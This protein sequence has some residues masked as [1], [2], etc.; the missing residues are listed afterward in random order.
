MRKLWPWII[1]AGIVLLAGLRSR[2][3]D[4]FPGRGGGSG[5]SITGAYNFA[6][7]QFNQIQT[8]NISIKDGTIITNPAIQGILGASTAVNANTL[9]STNSLDFVGAPNGGTL[10]NAHFNN[11]LGS[12]ALSS[13]A[14][15]SNNTIAAYESGIAG[16]GNRI[17]DSGF[18][19]RVV[20]IFAEFSTIS[21]GSAHSIIVG[22]L[23][24]Y[25]FQSRYSII[26]GWS[27]QVM[28]YSN[29]GVLSGWKNYC[30]APNSTIPGGYLNLI[31]VNTG[32]ALDT[33]LSQNSSAIGGGYSNRITG[34]AY[35]VIGGGYK[36]AITNLNGATEGNGLFCGYQ[37]IIGGN[38]P[39]YSVMCGGSFNL[40]KSGGNNFLG[41]GS[42]NNITDSSL[43]AITS[44]YQNSISNANYCFIGA[45]NTNV[46]R[47]SDYSFIV[48]G[49]GN[50]IT[51]RNNA[52][53]IGQAL[54]VTS[55]NV[56]EVGVNNV[57]K[58]R[59]HASGA[60]FLG[61]ISG[62]TNINLAEI[63]SAPT[64]AT[65]TAS[66]YVKD[67]AGIAK[68][69]M[70]WDDGTETLLGAGG[71]GTPGG[72]DTQLQVNNSGSFGG[73]AGITSP[74]NANNLK[75]A[76]WSLTIGA[77]TNGNGL[78][79]T[80][81][82]RFYG[83]SGPGSIIL[84]AATSGSFEITPSIAIIQTNSIVPNIVAPVADQALVIHSVAAA[85]GTNVITLTNRA[86]SGTPGGSDTHVQ[87]KSGSSFD[88][89]SGVV[90]PT[91]SGET[92]LNVTGLISTFN[93]LATNQIQVTGAGANG[94]NNLTVTNDATSSGGLRIL[95]PNASGSNA[96][97][98][99]TYYILN[100][101]YTNRAGDAVLTN[102]AALT[103]PANMLTNTYDAVEV[104]I[105]GSAQQAT[106]TTNQI[107]VLY[108]SETL[109]DSGLLGLSNSAWRCQIYIN[110]TGN[111]N[112]IYQATL[113][114]GTPSGVTNFTGGLFQTNGI[115]TTLQVQL[116]SRKPGGITNDFINAKYWPAP[117]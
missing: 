93:L 33:R 20:F 9:R 70:K 110:R 116:A 80:N 43:G 96:W 44:G 104:N 29:I 114:G 69:Y 112:Q 98:G 8:T 117:R 64:P 41:A 40:L 88:G 19:N 99:G 74:D 25:M 47:N 101:G 78:T 31:S 72:S 84:N 67:N 32:D 108:G 75:V 46:I 107:K 45:G 37:N 90:I 52:G 48:G 55:N 11:S 50:I 94:M 7:S 115:A 12:A 61:T 66:L 56:V 106:A 83:S 39:A 34:Q 87:Y 15:G 109:L 58:T 27:N 68:V 103:V 92:N 95:T 10:I 79:V 51:N 77:V 3:Q 5:G 85:G 97:V 4:T 91:S 63:P 73:L 111:S 22:G 18:S 24:N 35:G 81:T 57:R 14:F 65:N 16:S 2:G 17:Y 26:G 59:F 49:D 28:N 113:W 89:A 76:G 86:V 42:E 6:T 71:S 62:Q 23:S 21:N 36:N 102:A 100:Q 54:N 105:S 82:A 60:D 30:E 13:F 53:A 1:L 38:A